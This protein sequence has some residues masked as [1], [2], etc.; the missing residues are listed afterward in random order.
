MSKIIEH[1]IIESLKKL[2][3][4]EASAE[5]IRVENAIYNLKRRLS[6]YEE[7]DRLRAIKG[8][9]SKLE[10]LIEKRYN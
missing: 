10:L 2:Y 1:E 5:Q 6:K 4:S 9:V 8:I 3:D 7:I